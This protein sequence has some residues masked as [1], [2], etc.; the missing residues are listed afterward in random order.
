VDLALC[1]EKDGGKL[2]TMWHVNIS[3]L[4]VRRR[5]SFVL[6]SGMEN[7][8]LEAERAVRRW[9]SNS[10]IIA[11]ALDEREQ[12]PYPPALTFPLGE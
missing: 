1:R 3:L 4:L 8:V 9:K 11:D 10:W 12:V 7:D 5:F 6:Y 2:L